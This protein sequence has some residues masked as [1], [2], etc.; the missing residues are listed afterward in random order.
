MYDKELALD[1]LSNIKS[2]LEM[3]TQRAAV[4]A[5]PDDFFIIAGWYVAFGCYLYKP[6]RIGR[7]CERFG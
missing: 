2:A 6:N 4:A 3:I 7:S 5:T 1:S